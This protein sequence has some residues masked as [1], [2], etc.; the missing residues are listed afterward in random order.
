[1]SLGDLRRRDQSFRSGQSAFSSASVSA[2]RLVKRLGPRHLGNNRSTWPCRAAPHLGYHPVKKLTDQ[3]QR[4]HL[5]V[6]LSSREAQQFAAQRRI[7]IRI[8]RNVQPFQAILPRMD[9]ALTALSPRVG[10]HRSPH[11]LALPLPPLH[12]R[13]NA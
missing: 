3:S 1:M 8:D 9:C 13:A 2:I 6:M 4:I 12:E 11:R 10:K 7:P 5:I